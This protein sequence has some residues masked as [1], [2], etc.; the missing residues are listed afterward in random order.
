[1]DG[2]PLTL[3]QIRTFFDS[4]NLEELLENLTQKGYLK[5]E[6]PE[7]LIRETNENEVVT[8]SYTH[9]RAHETQAKQVCRLLRERKKE[10]KK[11]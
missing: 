10:H 5:F 8:D 4:P 3:E 7:K 11:R 2:M 1:M 9:I 6:S